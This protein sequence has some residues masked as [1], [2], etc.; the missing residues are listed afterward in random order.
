MPQRGKL[1]FGR[2]TTKPGWYKRSEIPVGGGR[3]KD[4]AG[5]FLWEGSTCGYPLVINKV[6][7][8]GCPFVHTN[9]GFTP[10]S[11]PNS[12]RHS[13]SRGADAAQRDFRS[14]SVLAAMF[15]VADLCFVPIAD[16][17]SKYGSY[18][19]SSKRSNDEYNWICGA[20]SEA[21][22]LPEQA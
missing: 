4:P 9:T 2:K 11:T 10:P 5:V 19:S 3:P 15:T 18:Y 14:K 8:G 22:T 16:P 17:N 13:I 12:G 6:A 21:R 20:G 1:G 7:D